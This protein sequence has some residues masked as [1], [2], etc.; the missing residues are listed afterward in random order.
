ML[1][2]LHEINRIALS[3]LTYASSLVA[4]AFSSPFSPYSYLPYS[5]RV[6]ARYDLFNRISKEY[7]KPEWGIDEVEINGES[8]SVTP[9]AVITKPFC[10]LIHFKR[11]ASKNPG[12]DPTVLIVAPMSGHHATLLRDTVRRMLTDFDVYITDWVDA[13]NVPVN[14]GAFDLDEYVYYIISFLHALNKRVHIMAVCQPSVPVFGAVSLMSQQNDPLVPLSMTLMGGPIDTKRSPTVVNDLADKHPLSWF[15]T[16]MIQRVPSRYPGAGRLVYPGFMQLMGFIAMN[17]RNHMKSYHEY[18]LDLMRGNEPE[19]EKH[20]SFYDEYNAVCDLPAEFYLQTVKVVFQDNALAKGTWK[21]GSHLINP[22][23][24]TSTALLTVEG[25][26][27]DITGIGQTSA[28]HDLTPHLPADKKEVFVAEG[29]GHYGI[30]SGSRWRNNVFPVV[31]NFINAAQEDEEQQLLARLRAEVELAI[32]KENEAK[33]R[34]KMREQARMQRKAA[35][36]AEIAKAKAREEALEKAKQ[37][38]LE[39]AE[40]EAKLLASAR[41]KAAEE[42]KAKAE[43]EKKAAAE[44]ERFAKTAEAKANAEAQSQ[45]TTVGAKPSS[46]QTASGKAAQ[47]TIG[48]LA[49]ETTT[50]ASTPKQ[51]TRKQVAR[52]MTPPA[53]KK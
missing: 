7:Q 3:P 51:A 35:E 19:A 43:A 34:A 27:D 8:V 46:P 29:S 21:V 44:A 36:E 38:A 45:A 4:E 18:Y 39:A 30:F 24:I 2:T 26:L 42:A 41:A 22:S 32:R 10:H 25:E 13:R 47:R 33:E 37:E 14:Q 6:A 15:E 49:A 52:K 23:A 28:A 12:G 17:P 20:R 40:A 9:E 16:Q 48:G 11:S 53:A 31:A 5:R 50:A 1:Y